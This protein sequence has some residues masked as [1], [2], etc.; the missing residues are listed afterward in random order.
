MRSAAVSF[1]MLLLVLV[2]SPLKK[3]SIRKLPEKEIL[4]K[5]AIIR[6]MLTVSVDEVY[7]I[8]TLKEMILCLI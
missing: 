2:Y 7:I 8:F 3:K 1:N 6:K 4:N 5:N